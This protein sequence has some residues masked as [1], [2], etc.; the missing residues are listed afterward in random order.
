LKL[1]KMEPDRVAEEAE[2]ADI[3]RG[4]LAVQARTATEENRPLRRATHAKG[5][6]VRAVFE[7]LDVGQGRDPV[8]AQLLDTERTL[9]QGKRR[10]AAFWIENAAVEWPEAQSPFHT[11]ARLT[12]LPRSQLSPEASEAMYIDV[13][14]NCTADSLPVGG[15]NRVRWYAEVAS[16]NARLGK[17]PHVDEDAG[18]RGDT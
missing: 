4:V 13:R 2:I 15:I 1:A 16:R 12:L 9:Y 14:S 3:A 11:V 10:D 8:L 17:P 7:V 18:M 5:V 6:C